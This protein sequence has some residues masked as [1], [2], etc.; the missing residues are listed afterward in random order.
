MMNY[1]MDSEDEWAEQNGEDLNEDAEMNKSDDD[2]DDLAE[3]EEAKG[4]IVDDDY[5]SASEMNYGD[6]EN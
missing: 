2:E 5:I 3:I 4:F 6:F 1:D